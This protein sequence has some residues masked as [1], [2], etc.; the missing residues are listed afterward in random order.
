MGQVLSCIWRFMYLDVLQPGDTFTMMMRKMFMAIGAIVGLAPMMSLTQVLLG[1]KE[2]TSTS[3]PCFISFVAILIGSWVYVKCTHTAPTW[4][5][6][7]WANSMSVVT[8]LQILTNPNAPWEYALIAYMF[9]V[10]I[11]KVP[12]VTLIVPVT[13]FLIFCYNFSLGRMGAPYRLMMLPDGFELP[14]GELVYAYIRGIFIILA[15]LYAVHLQSE[16]FT[17][18]SLAATAAIEMSLEVS[19][20]L[21]VYDTEG[22]RAV[23]AAYASRG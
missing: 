9:T 6:M 5:I 20:K 11:C 2:K 8:L 7:F 14:P 19:Q 21:A 22:A 15:P 1:L 17:R 13:A 4:L 10:L 12:S 23:L 16:E 3:Y 18:T